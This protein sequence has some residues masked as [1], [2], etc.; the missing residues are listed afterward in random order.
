V[1][2]I[3][4]GSSHRDAWQHAHELRAASRAA[5]DRAKALRIV[6]ELVRQESRELMESL[7]AEAHRRR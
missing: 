2:P 7:R 5:I 1:D 4:A 3:E 6:A